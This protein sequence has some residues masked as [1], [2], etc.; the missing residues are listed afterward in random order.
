MLQNSETALC[1]HEESSGDQQ[2]GQCK[3]A[4]ATG[5]FAFIDQ[6]GRHQKT[7][8][9]VHSKL[10]S[11]SNHQGLD[12]KFPTFT[13]QANS[14]FLKQETHIC[15]SPR[16]LPYSCTNM[17]TSYFLGSHFPN[18]EKRSVHLQSKHRC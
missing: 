7:V 12:Q 3:A 1:C 18:P 16:E 13:R 17:L 9:V 11:H 4:R 15:G 14:E 5:T 2:M 10:F 8:P 6:L